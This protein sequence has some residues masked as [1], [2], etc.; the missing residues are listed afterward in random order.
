MVPGTH[1]LAHCTPVPYWP[2]DAAAQHRHGIGPACTQNSGLPGEAWCICIGHIV[3]CY[4]KGS[5]LCLKG[6][7][8]DGDSAKCCPHTLH[9]PV[10]C[11]CALGCG[12]CPIISDG[13]IPTE[14]IERE[15]YILQ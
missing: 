10:E 4:I 8:G 1:H 6:T 14:G 12:A 3:G 15:L 9:L 2:L 5:L 11:G 7:K 13:N